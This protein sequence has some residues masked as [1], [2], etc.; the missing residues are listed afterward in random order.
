ML[1]LRPL[2]FAAVNIRTNV[3]LNAR[4]IRMTINV[5]LL[6]TFVCWLL[7][8]GCFFFRYRQ[9]KVRCYSLILIQQSDSWNSKKISLQFQSQ[10]LFSLHP[11]NHIVNQESKSRNSLGWIF[12]PLLRSF[13]EKR[14]LPGF[15]DANRATSQQSFF[16]AIPTVATCK[17]RPECRPRESQTCV[18]RAF[19]GAHCSCDGLCCMVFMHNTKVY[20]LVWF[21]RAQ[22]PTALHSIAKQ[23]IHTLQTGQWTHGLPAPLLRGPSQR[24]PATQLFSGLRPRAWL[25]KSTSQMTESFVVNTTQLVQLHWPLLQVW[26]IRCNKIVCSTSCVGQRVHMPIVCNHWACGGV[27]SSRLVPPWFSHQQSVSSS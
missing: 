1:R 24:E 14:E 26:F 17:T 27:R 21:L 12:K 22:T 11:R 20:L 6:V 13:R 7:G 25:W 8:F 10:M 23:R 3:I 4:L 18:R 5:A 16:S 9:R 15:L 19:S 2:P